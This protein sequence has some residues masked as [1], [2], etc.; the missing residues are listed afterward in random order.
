MVLSLP[1][2]GG[3]KS[4]IQVHRQQPEVWKGSHTGQQADAVDSVL[5]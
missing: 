4:E 5:A 3:T 1:P 2:V